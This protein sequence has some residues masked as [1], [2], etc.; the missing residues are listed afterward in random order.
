MSESASTDDKKLVLPP[1][2]GERLRVGLPDVAEQTV[3]ALIAEVPGYAEALSGTMRTNMERGVEMALGG[4]IRLAEKAGG[5]EPLQPVLD[6]AYELGRGEARDGRTMDDLLAAYRVGAR[7]SWREF[8]SVMVNG[9]LSAGVVAGFAELVFAYIVELSAASVAGHEDE[10]ATTGRVKEIYLDRLGRRLIERAPAEDLVEA[11]ERAGW[12][13]ASTLAAVLVPEADARKALAR[14]DSRTLSLPGG[15]VEDDE[16]AILLVPDVDGDRRE[17]MMK[18]LSGTNAIVGPTRPWTDVAVSLERALRIRE[19]DI[20][21]TG[22]VVDTEEHLATLLISSDRAALADLRTRALAP[23]ADLRPAAAGKLE[24]TLRSW[25]LHQGRRD[26]V[27]ADLFI[28]P[29]TVRYRMTQIRELFGDRLL[30]PE[31]VRDLV[32]ALAPG[33]SESPAR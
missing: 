6:G 2:I 24:L 9:G 5:A 11:A 7:V 22:E 33:S 18:A 12:E 31:S 19:L 28:H 30:E 8:S 32:I 27:A 10:R 21:E 15:I 20:A 16:L 1:E 14:L 25:L 17:P 26:D 23:L 13:P 3:I 4:F 29:Q